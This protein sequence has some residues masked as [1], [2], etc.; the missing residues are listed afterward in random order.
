MFIRQLQLRVYR[1]EGDERL[2]MGR[3]PRLAFAILNRADWITWNGCDWPTALEATTVTLECRHI[4]P[5]AG[6][7]GVGHKTMLISALRDLN[8]AWGDEKWGVLLPAG[9]S[10]VAAVIG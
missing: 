1:A 7:G 3:R 6:W 9:G 2:V 8:Q 10:R 4:E 5:C